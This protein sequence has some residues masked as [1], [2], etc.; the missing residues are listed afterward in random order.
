[1]KK[2]CVLSALTLTACGGGGDS[3]T[4]QN[5]PIASNSTSNSQPA[6]FYSEVKNAIPSL[7]T[8]YNSLPC[9]K[10]ANVYFMPSIDVNNDKRNDLFLMLWCENNSSV[11][12]NDASTN[13]IVSLMQNS[14]GT[15]RLGNQ[16]LFGKDNISLHG[17]L[18]E[19]FD[20]GLGDFNNDGKQDIALSPTLEDGRY[21]VRYENGSN[22]WDSY[23][24]VLMSQP[25][26]TYKFE[27][28]PN[29]GTLNSIVVFKEN[30]IDK[31][32]TGSYVYS[33]Q[34]Q[35]WHSQSM[36]DRSYIIDT[37]TAFFDNYVATQVFD[38][39]KMGIKVGSTSAG[40]FS[41]SD[42][43][44]ISKL[45]KVQVYDSNVLGDYTFS[46]ATIDGTDWVMPALPTSCSIAIGNDEIL[47]F[48]DFQGIKLSEKYNGQKLT[49]TTP[50]K[51]GNVSWEN[52]FTKVLAFKV[53]GNKITKLDTTVFDN[54]Y[55]TTYGLSCMDVNADNQK[56]VVLYRWGQEK[57][58]I[59]LNNNSSFNIVPENKIPNSNKTW[60]GH[61]SLITDLDG[62]NKTEVIYS[63]GLGYNEDYAG[64]YDDYLV[65]RA[66][67]PL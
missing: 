23:P 3:P 30:N 50:N 10:K 24:Y 43:Y 40:N 4:S 45:Q 22:N 7:S 41:Q 63:P 65:Y 13:L 57:S 34:N 35:K 54:E 44:E 60:K 19:H 25:D 1:M 27:Q 39:E 2:L 16:E 58:V 33:Y 15:F 62:D 51:T 21:F 12:H 66:V 67:N 5:S 37:S 6:V 20:A 28:L 52:Y 49:W 48:V 29:K 47:Y 61:H 31:I 46:M 59:W 64:Q 42:F 18:G 32:A 53:S 14:D 38:N 11:T 8:F 55:K 9:G 36:S 17:V 26:L 56:D